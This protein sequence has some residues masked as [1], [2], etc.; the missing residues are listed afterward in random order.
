[1]GVLLLLLVELYVGDVHS[2]GKGGGG[3]GASGPYAADGE[4]EDNAEGVVVDPVCWLFEGGSVKGVVVYAVYEEVQVVGVPFQ[5]KKV[6]VIGEIATRQF[7]STVEVS[8]AV[9]CSMNKIRLLANILHS[10]NFAAG[11]P[12]N[13]RTV[14]A[15]QPEG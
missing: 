14:V 1:M 4:V 9:R 11:G 15:K 6:V 12:A 3:V 10:V 13:C 8:W 7:V 5:G 2:L